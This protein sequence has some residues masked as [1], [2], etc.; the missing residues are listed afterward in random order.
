MESK[1]KKTYQRYSN[2]VTKITVKC[3][4]K[5]KRKFDEIVA[6]THKSKTAHVLDMI[7]S[8]YRE[9]FIDGV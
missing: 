9:L 1:P 6:A 8:T 2:K 5:E 4:P 7:N 3:T